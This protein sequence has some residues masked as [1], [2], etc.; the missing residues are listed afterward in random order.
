MPPKNTKSHKKKVSLRHCQI[1]KKEWQSCLLIKWFLQRVYVATVQADV[2]GSGLHSLYRLSTLKYLHHRVISGTKQEE[3]EAM[4]TGEQVPRPFEPRSISSQS[5]EEPVAW[6]ISLHQLLHPCINPNRNRLRATINKSCS[7]SQEEPADDEVDG[8]G[9]GLDSGFSE[10][11]LVSRPKFITKEAAGVEDLIS[12][13][14]PSFCCVP[15]TF[16]RLLL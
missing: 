15:S 8:V 6:V 9:L 16:H 5:G 13:L 7:D 2:S 10:A 12:C 1:P 3:T 14:E 4:T 11:K